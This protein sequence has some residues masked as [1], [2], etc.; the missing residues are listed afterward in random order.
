MAISL[1][2]TGAASD[3]SLK[4]LTKKY[5]DLPP[6]YVEFL[7]IHDGVEPPPNVLSGTNYGVTVTAFL[8]A[9]EIIDN[10]NS[11]E[12]LSRSLLPFGEDGSGNFVCIGADDHRVYFWDHEIDSD[13]IVAENFGEFL[14]RLEPLD[15]SSVTLKP[16]QDLGGWVDPDFKPEF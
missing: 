4:A 11:I 3:A 13:K 2:R 10:A 14:E 15:L 1:A 8:P 16:G 5:G 6:E 9:S 7:A 12:G